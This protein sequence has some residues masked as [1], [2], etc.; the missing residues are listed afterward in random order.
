MNVV[1]A[2]HGVW[3]RNMQDVTCRIG[4][5]EALVC[6][7][8]RDSCCQIEVDEAHITQSRQS[9]GAVGASVISDQH[10][11]IFEGQFLNVCHRVGGLTS[12]DGTNEHGLCVDA[13][14]AE[15]CECDM[16]FFYLFVFRF[17]QI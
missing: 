12:C 4:I 11:A 10:I 8:L 16:A 2:L 5:G 14:A 9:K 15:E 6:C 1:D 3:P 17:E 13:K 7:Y